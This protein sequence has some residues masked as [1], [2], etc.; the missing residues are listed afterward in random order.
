MTRLLA[1]ATGRPDKAA[2]FFSHVAG[3]ALRR[4]PAW[5]WWRPRRRFRDAATQLRWP[6]LWAASRS[7]AILTNNGTWRVCRWRSTT[8]AFAIARPAVRPA[9]CRSAGHAGRRV[10]GLRDVD[11]HVVGVWIDAVEP[12]QVVVH[13]ARDRRGRVLA[14]VQPDDAAGRAEAVRAP[15]VA[16]RTPPRPSLLK[17]RRLISASAGCQPEDARLRIAGLRQRRHGAD[18]D[19][20]ETH[21]A[22]AVDAAP[23]LIQAR[24]QADPGWEKCRPARVTG[25]LMRRCCHSRMRRRVLQRWRCCRAS[26]REPAP[27]PG[28]TG[29]GGSGCRVRRAVASARFWPR[30]RPFEAKNGP[31]IIVR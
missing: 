14:D 29:T 2:G 31:W 12:E 9:P 22:Q 5:C 10:L 20:A 3:L 11:G 23:V 6:R 25:S 16:P 24:G 27:G 7:G 8:A 15:H 30:W 17:P 21:R 26:A 18:L 4:V 13:R 28:R 1:S 19:E